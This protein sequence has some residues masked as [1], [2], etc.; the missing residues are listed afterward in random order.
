[1]RGRR[2]GAAALLF[3][4]LAATGAPAA[5][6]QAPAL[7]GDWLDRSP[8][9]WNWPGAPMPRAPEAGEEARNREY[10]EATI[11]LPSSDVDRALT[12]AGWF[13]FGAVQGWGD[14]VV[15]MANAAWDGMCRPWKYQ[16]FVFVGGRFAGTLSP[17]LMD[18]R[19]D[20]AGQRVTLA[21]GSELTADFLRYGETD[22][23]CCPTRL[24]EARFQIIRGAEGP[25]VVP[26]GTATRPV[27]R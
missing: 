22:P 4:V 2:A 7:G 27:P 14:A 17:V 6:A 26:L 3:V 19:T 18:S 15:L 10:C 21:S 9:A 24:T 12:D 20:G 5:V 11:R 13:L 8:V 16:F 23:L 25:V 1:V